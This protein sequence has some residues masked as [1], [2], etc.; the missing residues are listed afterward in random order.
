MPSTLHPKLKDLQDGRE[1]DFGGGK[2]DSEELRSFLLQLQPNAG[3]TPRCFISNAVFEHKVDLSDGRDPSGSAL[4][5]LEFHG[6]TFHQGFCADGAHIE[7]LKF[8][9]CSFTARENARSV[10]W[11]ATKPCES[12]KSSQDLTQRLR[13][14]VNCISLRHCWVNTELRLEFLSPVDHQGEPGVLTVDA[15]AIRV[16]T[17]VHISDTTLR[18]QEGESSP[19]SEEAHYALHLATASVNGDVQLMPNVILDGGLKMRD[20][21]VGGSLWGMGLTVTDGE[22]RSRNEL[23]KHGYPPR[24]A[25]WLDTTEIQGN[26]GLS[27]FA[28]EVFHAEGAVKL[29]NAV[30]AGDFIIEGEI[31]DSLVMQGATVKGR[32][33]ISGELWVFGGGQS[34]IE[35]NCTIAC[36]GLRSCDLSGASFRGTLDVS[37]SVFVERYLPEVRAIALSPKLTCYPEMR[38]AEVLCFTD[39]LRRPA[40]LYIASFLV[41]EK[42]NDTPVFLDGNSNRLHTLNRR[43]PT[44][45]KLDKPEEAR[46]YLKLFCASVWGDWG[47]F[48][49]IDE[50]A[51]VPQNFPREKLDRRRLAFQ[52]HRKGELWTAL[53]YVRYADEFFEAEFHGDRK[54]GVQMIG[55]AI[56]V[57]EYRG[58][59]DEAR[60]TMFAK[61]Y[62]VAPAN[63]S[64]YWSDFMGL[65][66]VFRALAPGS[67]EVIFWQNVLKQ[68]EAFLYPSADLSAASCKQLLDWRPDI[69]KLEHEFDPSLPAD[70]KLVWPRSMRLEE[71][72]YRQ[73]AV[74]YE[75]PTGERKRLGW[76][77]GTVEIP[78][79][80][81]WFSF[82][83]FVLTAALLCVFVVAALALAWLW[84][85]R[86]AFPT[87]ESSAHFGW[88][89]LAVFAVLL[90]AGYVKGFQM[91]EARA[92][93]PPLRLQDF[94]INRLR[95]L[96]RRTRLWHRR[97]SSPRT[98][99][100]QPYTHLAT[101]L[102]GRG[103][104]VAARDVEAEKLWL[105]A[106]TRGETEYWQWLAKHLLW[107]PY[108]VMF[109]FGLSPMRA[110]LSLI[111]F[112]CLGWA[113]T[114]LLSNNG[115]LRSSVT[116]VAPAVLME[117]K[118]PRPALEDLYASRGKAVA[119]DFSCQEEIE[120]ALYAFELMTPIVN[121]HQDSRCGLR[122]RPNDP[123]GKTP[124]IKIAPGIPLPL[125]F[126]YGWFW[127]YA[128][129]VYMVVG[130]VIT[131]LALL[132]VSGIARRWEH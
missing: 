82:E 2:I 42:E 115:M 33:L 116:T 30:I 54:G 11:P 80:D 13:K 28:G 62:R 121:L 75:D 88:R 84:S 128:K 19:L 6:C 90:F 4:P 67:P 3:K 8:Y 87:D 18:A 76:V 66:P 98:F 21:Q 110:F 29:L 60:L 89:F 53:G 36:S 1:A 117:G 123:A 15:F 108:G 114:Y 9:C 32:L 51:G 68:E 63:F 129:A 86:V 102:R 132:T 40:D 124:K 100:A 101:V 24:N 57:G 106:A 23:T 47:S 70:Q 71:F 34:T 52:V 44:A 17:N 50:E 92:K 73:L 91:W 64:Q 59:V 103:D 65:L 5:A 56:R 7:R 130:S 22:H 58:A 16:G 120:P 118:Q 39:A 127:E 99:S 10:K 45:L 111:L 43:S 27:E 85:V 96:L 122:S 107:R 126:S 35:G 104:D 77:R 37:R 41:S 12:Y 38:V 113:A 48:A 105:E 55:E 31:R 61:P 25:L 79:L 109:R 94:W 83:L 119:A 125:L 131:S 95:P 69:R 78:E 20:A 72:D 14:P 46:E 112:W 49:I 97:A 26:L 93:T 81:P 74:S